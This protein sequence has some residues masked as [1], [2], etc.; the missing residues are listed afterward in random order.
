[1]ADTRC[2]RRG[3]ALSGLIGLSWEGPRVMSGAVTNPKGQPEL[4]LSVRLNTDVF[5]VRFEFGVVRKDRIGPWIRGKDRKGERSNSPLAYQG[6]G[7]GP[8]CSLIPAPIIHMDVP[9]STTDGRRRVSNPVQASCQQHLLSR[10]FLKRKVSDGTLP[11]PRGI[12][13]PRPRIQGSG[14]IPRE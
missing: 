4:P 2:S 6:P 5:Q 9:S 10:P 13:L 3:P 11:I 1:M 8:S 14:C 7:R 12:V